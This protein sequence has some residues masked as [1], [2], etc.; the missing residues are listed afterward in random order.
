MRGPTLTMSKLPDLTH[1]RIV[2]WLMAQS[3]AASLIESSRSTKV[4]SERILQNL[5]IT[6]RLG[7]GN[8]AESTRW[9]AFA[10]GASGSILLMTRF[11]WDLGMRMIHAPTLTPSN[12]PALSHFLIVHSV[13]PQSFAASATES[14]TSWAISLQLIRLCSEVIGRSCILVGGIVAPMCPS[15]TYIRADFTRLRNWDKFG[16]R[17]S[18][19]S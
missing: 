18:R 10:L 6:N 9:P 16:G 17:A 14:M 5:S 13:M 1:L 3:S 7:S 2:Q 15:L 8:C 11:N 4:S 12:L 19:T